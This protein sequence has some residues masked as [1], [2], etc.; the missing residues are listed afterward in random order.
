MNALLV[1]PEYPETFWSWKRIMKII[2]RKAA[3]PPLGLLTVAAMMPEKWQKRL[4]DLNVRQLTDEDIKWA[5]Y[6]FVSAMITQKKSAKEIIARCNRLG[7]KVIVGGPM[8]TTE[9]EESEGVDHFIIGEVED[10]F[11]VFL[12]DLQN[13][14]AKKVYTSD[15]HPDVAKTPIP[16]WKLI[17]PKDYVSLAFQISRGCP[18]D[19]EFCDITVLNGRIP[20]IKCAEQ[21]LRELDA[22][23]ETGFR[24]MVLVVDDNFIGNK[25]KV[26][27]ILLSMIEW[28]KKNGYSFNFSTEASINL[29]DDEELMKMMSEAG[30]TQVFLG[31]ETP[32][33]A[34]LAECGKKQNENRDVVACIKKIQNYGMH[35][36]GG[37]IVGFDSDPETIFDDQINF[38][39]Q[40]GVIA[41]MVGLLGALPKTKLYYRLLREGR[42][43]K[44]ST[45]NNTDCFL[46]FKSKMDS[47][48][49]MNGYKRVIKTIYSPKKYY[50]RICN[51]LN[52]YNPRARK[53]KRR[54]WTNYRAFLMSVWY[55]GIFGRWL[56][57]WYYWK[58]LFT[59][60][61]KYPKA[62][63]EAVA[64]QIWGLHLREVAEAIS[65]T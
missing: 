25:A 50:E 11:P 3:F 42:L 17:N 48:V 39:Q 22:I 8:F 23:R 15:V 51:F 32:S 2:R 61:L 16:S 10:I 7:K 28:Q 54:D 12:K 36:A 53:D 35:T 45:G 27:A 59:A 20:R 47:Q 55:I 58:T 14:C 49:L 63:P 40:T 4:V 19:C 60:L 21:I 41:A 44:T 6:I 57:R 5:D 37:F 26:K 64:M 13:G 18:F 38:I 31:L 52:E 43:L 29:A 33:A 1:Y 56:D 62:F 30:F 65:K 9:C 46:N 24:G 34:G